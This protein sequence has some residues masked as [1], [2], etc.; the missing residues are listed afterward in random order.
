MVNVSLPEIMKKQLDSIVKSGHFTSKSDVLKE[1]FRL[2][3]QNNPNLINSIAVQLG[4]EN[5]PI[6]QIVD[7][8]GLKNEEVKKILK[9]RGIKLNE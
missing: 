4:K 6:S 9:D 2:M 3:L 7:I 1:A 5:L 8:T